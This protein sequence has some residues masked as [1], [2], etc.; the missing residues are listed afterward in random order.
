MRYLQEMGDLSVGKIFSDG[1]AIIGRNLAWCVIGTVMIAVAYTACG[2]GTPQLFPAIQPA[3]LD[4]TAKLLAWPLVTVVQYVMVTRIMQVEGLTNQGASLPVGLFFFL[5][6]LLATL[7]VMVGMVF[8]IVPGVILSL[9]WALA[10]NLVI[11][12]G[13]QP[14]AALEESWRRT[15]GYAGRICGVMF[16][17]GIAMMAAGGVAGFIV[18]AEGLAGTLSGQAI[19]HL[20]TGVT[21]TAIIGINL[22]IYAALVG[23]DNDHLAEVFA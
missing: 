2:W 9:R 14:M 15:D 5:T 7:G 4:M 20:V 3:L 23:P 21:A 1:I 18:G 8:L 19:I 17:A 12:R 16:L 22:A 13:L 6:G 11:G 10:V